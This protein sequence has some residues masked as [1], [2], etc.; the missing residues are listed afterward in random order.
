MRISKMLG[1]TMVAGALATGGPAGAAAAS[2]APTSTPTGTTSGD[3]SV[4]AASTSPAGTK[5]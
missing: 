4:P 5:Q 1:A 2:P 3:S